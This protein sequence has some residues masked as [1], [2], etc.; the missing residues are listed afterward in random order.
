[1]QHGE[2]VA[3]ASYFGGF[4][5]LCRGDPFW[6]RRAR[7]DRY[8]GQTWQD[9]SPA[10]QPLRESARESFE[11]HLRVAPLSGGRMQTTRSPGMVVDFLNSAQ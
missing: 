9:V 6:V 4:V 7:V 5:A 11:S 3:I 8:F 10:L 2:R 1:M